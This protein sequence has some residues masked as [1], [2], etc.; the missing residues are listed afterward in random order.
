V[1]NVKPRL[2]EFPAPQGGRLSAEM[3][4]AFE[5]AGVII[6]RGFVE[7]DAC[8]ALQAR[9]SELVDAFDPQSV[10]SIFSSKSN[11]Q[12]GDEYFIRSG[13]DI[14]FFF[15]ED[16]FDAAGDLKHDKRHSI[17]KMGHAMHDIDPLFD[18]F[19]R[20]PELAALAASLGVADP[21]LVQSMYIFKPPRIG[22]EVV[23]HQ[24]STYLYTEPETCIGFWFA[25]DDA[26]EGNGCMQFVP[27]GHKAPL[28]RLNYRTEEGALVTD[29]IDDAPLNDHLAAPA[30]AACGDL[31]IFHGRAPHM[32]A[33]NR[34]AR[35]RHAYTLHIV[36]GAA[37]WPAQN[38]LQRPADF[39][40][41]GF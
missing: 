18:E 33:P 6:L 11:V 37:H 16:A 8:K 21:L 23:C 19:S 3:R 28:R 22:G 15:E 14:G 40:F 5:E 13:G 2:P 35:S 32:S 41:R 1:A 9:T 7:P 12:L 25:I 31:V 27:G 24:D 38:W 10:R 36:D 26:D 17:N 30:P 20:A 29:V 34:S 39:P 4:A